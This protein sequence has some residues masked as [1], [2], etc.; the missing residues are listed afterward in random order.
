MAWYLNT[1]SAYATG[2]RYNADRSDECAT[3]QER[4]ADSYAAVLANRYRR[5]AKRLRAMAHLC[6][7]SAAE[8]AGDIDFF[9]MM[10]PSQSEADEDAAIKKA[11]SLKAEGR[12]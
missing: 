3:Y 1:P 5:Q 10:D 7:I 8:T 4:R 12:S 6:D 9:G 11:L 2:L